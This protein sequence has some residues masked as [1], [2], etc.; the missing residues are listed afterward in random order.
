MSRLLDSPFSSLTAWTEVLQDSTLDLLDSGKMES[1]SA[2]GLCLSPKGFERLYKNFGFY[3]SLIVLRPAQ[4]SNSPELIRRLGVIAMNTALEVD[5]YGHANST[6][7]NGSRMLY[8]VGGSGDFLRNAYLGIIHI[9]SARRTASDGWISSIV[10]MASHIDHTEHDVAIVVTE[11]GIADLRG[12][13][14]RQRAREL[15]RIAHP[16][17]RA[18]LTEYL[19]IAEAHARKNNCMHE[20]HV[21]GKALK[22][23]INMQQKGTMLLD[24]W[25]S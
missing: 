12:L 15:I 24:N 6:C 2:A 23:H 17:F 14:P 9:P 25:T 13:T 10:P 20:P 22:M 1:A 16:L 11:Q 4:I 18:Q 21:L 3:K 7:V 8:G 19:E 5:I